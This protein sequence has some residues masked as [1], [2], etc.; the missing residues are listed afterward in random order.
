MFNSIFYLRNE[1]HD[2]H[3]IREKVMNVLE[4]V[5]PHWKTHDWLSKKSLFTYQKIITH[6]IY[7][8]SSLLISQVLKYVTNFLIISDLYE[9]IL[10]RKVSAI[11]LA[12]EFLFSRISSFI[13]SLITASVILWVRI[14]S[15]LKWFD[16]D[17][18]FTL[19][20]FTFY[21]SFI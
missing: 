17:F 10:K 13:Y 1:W 4:F 12:Y 18:Q 11:S 19:I 21:L 16:N 9:L 6:D 5:A 20:Y 8:V 2:L 7:K 14:Y 15:R 3:P